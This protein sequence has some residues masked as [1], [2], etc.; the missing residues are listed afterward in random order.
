MKAKPIENFGTSIAELMR[1][2]ERVIA[3]QEKAIT[4]Q[5]RLYNDYHAGTKGL[6]G[7][8]RMEGLAAYRKRLA[9]SPRVVDNEPFLWAY[10]ILTRIGDGEIVSPLAEKMAREVAKGGE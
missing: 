2:R 4:E 3:E 6:T 9:T 1:E 8:A 10:A 7:Q 5:A